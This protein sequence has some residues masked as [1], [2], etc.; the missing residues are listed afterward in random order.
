LVYL[1]V[2]EKP[3]RYKVSCGP[4]AGGVAEGPKGVAG[5]VE[6]ISEKADG[7]FAQI[8][9]IQQGCLDR[10]AA[11]IIPNGS[12]IRQ[13]SSFHNPRNNELSMSVRV[14]SG[15]IDIPEEKRG[16]LIGEIIAFHAGNVAWRDFISKREN[17]YLTRQ[18]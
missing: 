9:R 17:R 18:K 11:V 4:V 2:R 6:L 5:Q 7:L 13:R 15:W 14:D 1:A 12:D 10:F 16:Q 3:C 8:R